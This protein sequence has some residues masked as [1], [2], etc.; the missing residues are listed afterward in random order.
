MSTRDHT[1]RML[2]SFGY[3]VEHRG[4]QVC[5]AGDGKLIGSSINI[6]ADISSAA[7]FMVGATIAG[8]SKLLLKHVGINP[9]RTGMIDILRRMGAKIELRNMTAAGSEPVADILV[10]SARLQGIEIPLGLVPLAIDEFPAIFIAAACASGKTILKGAQELR[11]KESDRLKV[12]ADGLQTCGINADPTADGMLIHGGQIRGGCVHS[13]GDHR[14]AMAFAIAGL[15]AVEPL[16]IEDCQNVNTS[17]PGFLAAAEQV[18]LR[19]S[20]PQ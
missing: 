1:E 19:I 3:R 9:T 20:S 18:G 13:H 10:E 5:L 8:G 6:P 14:I 7:F 17:F 16:T 2:S 15:K 11:I 4:N 12:M